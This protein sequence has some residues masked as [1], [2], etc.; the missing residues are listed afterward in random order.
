MV[1]GAIGLHI[2]GRPH[3]REAETAHGGMKTMA[4]G[5]LGRH[6]RERPHQRAY[7]GM[8]RMVGGRMLQHCGV[9]VANGPREC[10]GREGSRVIHPTHR[11]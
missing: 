4:G 9:A 7:G 3:Q 1:G 11:C 10:G 8:E 2:R 5:V 6:I